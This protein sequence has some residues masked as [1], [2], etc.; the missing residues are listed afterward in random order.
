[1]TRVV[2]VTREEMLERRQQLLD[3]AH[4]TLEDLAGRAR[5][6]DLLDDEWVLWSEIREVQFLLGEDLPAR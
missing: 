2:T 6:G 3:A 5:T 1:M 4:T